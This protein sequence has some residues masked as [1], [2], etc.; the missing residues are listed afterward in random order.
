M[1]EMYIL[2][3]SISI[4]TCYSDTGVIFNFEFK[5]KSFFSKNV[6]SPKKGFCL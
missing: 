3:V 4:S 6:G 5:Y 2:Y 1:C